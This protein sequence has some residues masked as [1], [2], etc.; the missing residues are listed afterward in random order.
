[1]LH[2]SQMVLF[3]SGNGGSWN[4]ARY[5]LST[6]GQYLQNMLMHFQNHSIPY[7]CSTHLL[8]GSRQRDTAQRNSAKDVA[9]IVMQVDIVDN[10]ATKIICLRKSVYWPYNQLFAHV[11]GSMGNTFNCNLF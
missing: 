8:G 2:L 9:K 7:F 3:L 6:K 1:M 5:R 4:C 10:V 11:F